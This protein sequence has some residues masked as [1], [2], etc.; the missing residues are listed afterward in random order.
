[1]IDY[2][3]LVREFKVGDVVQ[4][5]A[6]GTG[7]L[8]LSPFV[9]RVTAVH[10]GLGVLD[11]QFPYGVDRIFPDDVVVVQPSVS[12]W[13]PP[14]LIDQTYVGLDT[15]K[16]REVWASSSK[17]W[18]TTG[19]PAG[20]HRDLAQVW[21][22]GANE[23][24]AYDALWRRYATVGGNDTTMRS[25]IQKFYRVASNFVELRIQ[26]HAAKTAAYWAAANRQYRATSGDIGT[27]KPA[28]PKCG[29]GMRK[30]TYKMDKGARVRLFAC[31]KDLFLLRQ[32]DLLGPEGE[33]VEW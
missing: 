17:L 8:A 24:A 23:V 1:M 33:P 19:L 28:C 2:W 32:S 3:K 26:Q 25:E 16:A 9:G 14:S 20:F 29:T 7:G 27:R 12:N 30:T 18:E 22:K 6:P 10:R 4:R 13:L 11:V 31:P 21:S 15:E 5:F